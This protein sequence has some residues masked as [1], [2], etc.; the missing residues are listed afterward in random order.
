MLCKMLYTS[1][2]FSSGTTTDALGRSRQTTLGHPHSGLFHTHT[3]GTCYTALLQHVYTQTWCA[4]SHSAPL[5]T[6]KASS[7]ITFIHTHTYKGILHTMLLA[8]PTFTHENHLH[9]AS[10]HAQTSRSSQPCASPTT[11]IFLPATPFLR[12]S[13]AH[14]SSSLPHSPLLPGGH[15]PV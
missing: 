15:C 5:Y 4:P 12:T 9:S 6:H 10:S 13:L 1:D 3:R 11:T 14:L 7:R 8:H 2:I